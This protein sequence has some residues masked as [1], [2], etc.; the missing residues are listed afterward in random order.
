MPPQV[1]SYP[2]INGHRYSFASIE[3]AFNGLL[4]PGFKS[5]SYNDEL[6]PADVY[7][8]SSN[9]IGRTKGKQN[10]ACTFVMYKEEFENLRI[11]LGVTGVGY[12]ETQF[13]IILTYFEV[14]QVPITDII[15]GCRVTKT[16]ED[17]NADSSDALTVSVECNVM[18][19]IRG[20][21][22]TIAVPLPIP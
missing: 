9:K 8:T 16:S 15:Q 1:V 22:D 4:V 11:T 18:R 19:I 14:G 20:T 3:A 10:A 17:S 21:K 5:I 2:Q 6:T 12:G 7:G 13:D